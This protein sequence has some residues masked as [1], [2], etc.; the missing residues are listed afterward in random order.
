MMN[1]KEIKQKGSNE[2][3]IPQQRENLR[4]LATLVML[5][6]LTWLIALPFDQLLPSHTNPSMLASS[7]LRQNTKPNTQSHRS[8]RLRRQGL[9]PQGL[10][11][12]GDIR[13]VTVLRFDSR[14]LAR[15]LFS[16]GI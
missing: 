3:T 10:R 11:R 14:L 15:T 7:Q 12:H 1:E 13:P 2:V 9:R 6:R 4:E 8:Q 16:R 5:R